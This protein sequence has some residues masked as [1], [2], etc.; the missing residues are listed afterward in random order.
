MGVI[1]FYGD[2]ITPRSFRYRGLKIQRVP[3]NV[4][5]L[6]MDMNGTIHKATSITWGYGKD[7][8]TVDNLRRIAALTPQQIDMSFE[9]ILGDLLKDA[10][11]R[12][13]PRVYLIMCVDGIAPRAKINQQRQRRY[14][15][16]LEKTLAP[17]APALG[18]QAPSTFD[19]A[20]ITPGTK[21]MKRVDAYLR[22]WIAA[23]QASLPPTVIYSSHL[24]P[25]EGEHK[26]FR[27]MRQG[28]VKQGTGHHLIY[29]L[30]ADLIMLASLAPLS[31]IM[32]VRE[33]HT[34][35]VDIDIFKASM[36][37]DL[38]RPGEKLDEAQ[39]RLIVQD[40][41]LFIYLIGNDFL[42]HMP[43]F[44]DVGASMALLMN[45]YKD[46]ETSISRLTKADGAI[47]WVSLIRYLFALAQHEEDLIKT[48]GTK[49]F[50]YPS[51]IVEATMVRKAAPHDPQYLS[52]GSK[53]ERAQVRY[54]VEKFDF[55]LYRQLWYRRAF[56]PR[57]PEGEALLK[58]VGGEPYTLKD[59]EAM[60]NAY[61]YGLQWVLQYYMGGNVTQRF[62][63]GYLYP[64][65]LTDLFNV[66]YDNY[67]AQ[68]PNLVP[69]EAVLAKA[70]EALPD[71]FQQLVAVIPPQ[72]AALIPVPEVAEL[73]SNTGALVDL[74]PYAFIIEQENAQDFE[75]KLAILPALDIKRVADAVTRVTGGKVPEDLEPSKD[76]ET[77]RQGDILQRRPSPFG[78]GGGR[79]RGRGLPRGGGR[80]SGFTPRGGRG[81][82]GFAAPSPGGRGGGFT[83]RGGGLPAP[84]LGGRGSVSAVPIVSRL[85]PRGLPPPPSKQS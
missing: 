68:P 79:G 25:G 3:E 11:A 23:N 17:A 26:I 60:A 33:K 67:K 24:V 28:K 5:G 70:D 43:I 18:P 15:T 65:V 10:I 21:F 22:S 38:T 71:I 76:W 2:F 8:A 9:G 45:V 57:T 27:L 12:I 80:G 54:T 85:P 29:G 77:Q 7:G 63:Y 4:E 40:Y 16:A 36:I 14:K 59:I 50:K 58:R 52:Q 30:D 35:L 1:H 75:N 83:P 39:K 66:L 19:T 61:I 55:T 47:E 51:A 64:P 44:E 6:C 42:P 81:S 31:K 72:S 20:S 56:G 49:E 48:L 78:G 32:L 84:P 41:V 37:T 62:I 73:I 82:G 74:A 53:V 69:V 13:Q 34:D 46:P